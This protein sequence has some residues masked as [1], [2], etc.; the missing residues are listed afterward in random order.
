MLIG[1]WPFDRKPGEEFLESSTAYL[2]KVLREAKEHSSWAEPD[3]DYE[4]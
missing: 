3:E 4:E 1:A 2:Q